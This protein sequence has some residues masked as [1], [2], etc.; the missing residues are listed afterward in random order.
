MPDSTTPEITPSSDLTPKGS[1]KWETWILRI[2]FGA[3]IMATIGIF[4]FAIVI[5][6]ATT[7][8]S[9]IPYG[10]AI[11]MFA[12]VL[13]ILDYFRR[14]AEKAEDTKWQGTI[15]SVIIILLAVSI[16]VIAVIWVGTFAL[17]QVGILP[18][19]KVAVQVDEPPTSFVLSE[20]ITFSDPKLPDKVFGN[21]GDEVAR[22]RGWMQLMEYGAEAELGAQTTFRYW[23]LTDDF[24]NY[25]GFTAKVHV[26]TTDPVVI[27]AYF[28][29]P[30]SPT[31]FSPLPHAA[32]TSSS[33]TYEFHVPAS[34][35]GDRLL[36]FLTLKE[37]TFAKLSNVTTKFRITR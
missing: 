9:L 36:V 32:G 22:S 27:V 7:I 29:H 4:F 8:E 18:P 13:W 10:I 6:K 11:L 25:P 37:E 2:E 34:E 19:I 23:L 35:A 12:V 28:V 1:G 5:K 16:L 31:S 14:K 3:F 33:P 17:R 24:K 21:K 30:G 15:I 20:C 26:G